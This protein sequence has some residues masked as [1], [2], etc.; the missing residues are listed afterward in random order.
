VPAPAPAVT[1]AAD[2]GGL[3]AIR[4]QLDAVSDAERKGDYRA[5]AAGLQAAAAALDTAD[6]GY[7]TRLRGRA[8]EAELLLAWHDAVAAAVAGEAQLTLGTGAGTLAVVRDLAGCELVGERDGA[9][10]RLSWADVEAPT[11]RAMARQ[12]KVAGRAAIGAAVLLYRRADPS[13]AEALLA[14]AWQADAALQP[15]IAQVLARGRGEVVDA[16]GYTLGK[17]GFVSVRAAELQQES[18]QLGARLDVALRDKDTTRREALV[19]E[20]RAA[21]GD[22]L[23]VLAAALQREFTRQVARLD[24]S[25]LKKQVQKL[26]QQRAELDAARHDARSLIYD[27]AKY[28]YPY[29]PPQVSSDRYAAYLRV[30]AEIERRT[31]AVRTLWQDDRTKVRV[32]PS[33]SQDLERLGWLA[34]VLAQLGELDAAALAR[35]DW[36]RALPPGDVV[37]IRDYCASVAE[38]DELEDWRRVEAYNEL[39]GKSLSSAQRE[40]LRITNDYRTMFRHRP[41]A[42]VATLAAAS[43][44]HADEMSRLGYF[45][46]TSPTEGRGSPADRT[47]LAGYPGGAT[48][49][50]ALVDGAM[51][52]HLAWLTSSGH[53]RNLLDPGHHEVGL[54]ANGRYWVQNFSSGRVHRDSAEFAKV[55]ASR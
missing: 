27:E 19:D 44:G 39:V 54:G 8:E 52:A 46:H 15:A 18:Q 22:A 28:F 26:A 5:V 29:K 13:P 37:S 41:V 31:A 4:A 33:L 9:E 34:K 38:R 43:Q 11:L 7:A 53:H 49:N 45:S 24:G 14:E 55:A 12:L 6:R 16:R 2:A 25:A 47:R 50:I 36:A 17:S 21:G 48:E 35:V 20:A 1:A 3:A 30:Q 10:V 51:G 40:L 23:V 42:I 32:P